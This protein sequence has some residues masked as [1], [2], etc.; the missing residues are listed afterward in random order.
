MLKCK[1][2][3]IGSGET[4]IT[5]ARELAETKEKIILVE[6]S[7]LGGTY[8]QS[9]EYPKKF[10]TQESKDFSTAL[11]SL[12][13]HPDTFSVLR[14]FRQK[15]SDNILNQ[16][17]LESNAIL[18]NFEKTK[19]LRIINGIAEFSSKSLVE[20]N[21][22]QEKHLVNF[23]KVILAV[24]KNRMKKPTIKGIEKIDFLY[25][26]NAFL[27][28]N[29]P[30]KLAVI[31]CSEE[32]LEVASVYAGLGVKV[33]IFEQKNSQQ[34][35]P[36]LDRTA[37]NYAIKELMKR[38]VNFYF[39][40]KI[41]EIKKDKKKIIL[42]DDNRKEYEHSNVYLK[43]EEYFKENLLKLDK[44]DLPSNK[45]GI[46]TNNFG[47]TKYNHI[48]ALGDCSD[49]SNS[50]NKHSLIHSFIQKEKESLEKRNNVDKVLSLRNY[51]T[52][53][54]FL[55][56]GLRVKKINIHQP[57]VNVGLSERNAKAIHGTYIA[58]EVIENY[59]YSG[60]VKIVYKTNNN[61]VLGIICTGDFCLKFTDYAILAL[62]LNQDYKSVRNYFRGRY[63]I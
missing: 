24:G 19:N 48:Y 21:S 16:I 59:N 58:T 7:N 27:F 50:N 51:F 18:N 3:I 4:G 9:L 44:I 47:K 5:L 12:K 14:K 17:K 26:H 13:N 34:S 25:K 36:K 53:K 29:I 38:N 40:T 1:Y 43:I 41:K 22:E 23:E 39:E 31:G 35:I 42:I 60:F 63:G 57:V 55:Y 30:T 52:E 45:K 2:L 46:E 54:N 6:Q 56:S 33:S 32:T 20:I 11:R 15:I 28:L 10:L 37:F 8:L 61:Q 49:K 62:T